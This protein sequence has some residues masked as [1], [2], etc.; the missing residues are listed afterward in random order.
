MKKMIFV[1]VGMLFVGCVERGGTSQTE[2]QTKKEIVCHSGGVVTY[3]GTSDDV[4]LGANWIWFDED[5][6]GNKMNISNS[7]ACV[8]RER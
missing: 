7:G 2:K 1:V 5:S 3:R 8:I 4:Y 6:T